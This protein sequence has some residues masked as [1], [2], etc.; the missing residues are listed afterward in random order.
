MH[1]GGNQPI[2]KPVVFNLVNEIGDLDLAITAPNQIG[3]ILFMP[4][5]IQIK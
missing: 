3:T 1:I 4:T 5:E 2:L